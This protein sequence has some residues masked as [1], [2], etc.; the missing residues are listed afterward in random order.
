MGRC[1]PLR[2]DI[3]DITSIEIV[4]CYHDL[5]RGILPLFTHVLVTGKVSGSDSVVILLSSS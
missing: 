5:K 4:T 2:F 1:L 3:K